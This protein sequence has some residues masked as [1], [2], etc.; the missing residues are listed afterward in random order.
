M[1]VWA[2]F[3]CLMCK[4]LK[5]VAA[6]QK[7]VMLLSCSQHLSAVTP[8]QSETNL[9]VAPASS[10]T[11]FAR[12]ESEFLDPIAVMGRALVQPY[13]FRY[14]VLCQYISPSRILVGHFVPF[15]FFIFI[16]FS[17]CWINLVNIC[18][19]PYIILKCLCLS[20]VQKRAGGG[21][22][23]EDGNRHEDEAVPPLDEERGAGPADLHRRLSGTESILDDRHACLDV[24]THT[25][26]RHAVWETYLYRK[27]I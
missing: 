18:S 2:S 21:D 10:F 13:G 8:D 15:R 23:G 19:V 12:A 24:N 6:F 14:C 26:G 20:G 7:S 5:S 4:Y 22:E 27:I 25:E 11:S 9:P 17:L 3:T 16:L 1:S